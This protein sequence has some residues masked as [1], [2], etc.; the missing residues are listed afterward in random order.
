LGPGYES[1]PVRVISVTTSSVKG[2]KI[3]KVGILNQTPKTLV[4]VRFKW[5]LSTE[6][7]PEKILLSGETPLVGISVSTEEKRAVDFPVFSLGKVSKSLLKEGSLKG[8]YQVVVAVTEILFEDGSS[9]KWGDSSFSKIKA[10]TSPASQSGCAFQKCTTIGKGRDT[11]THLCDSSRGVYI[12]C[13]NEGT[14]CTNVT[15]H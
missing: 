8:S 7:S 5:E 11:I 9:W 14:Q 13:R 3:S 1:M 12:Y 15:C 2:V 10:K 6:Q 4:G